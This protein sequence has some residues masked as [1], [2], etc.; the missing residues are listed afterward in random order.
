[1]GP[2]RAS[3]HDGI[4]K[5]GF[6][7][8]PR[9]SSDLVRGALAHSARY[10]TPRCDAPA[11]QPC[12]TNKPMGASSGVWWQHHPLTTDSLMEQSLEVEAL[13]QTYFCAATRSDAEV[14]RQ[15]RGGTKRGEQGQPW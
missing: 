10:A 7:H 13:D 1:L 4:R 12:R 14:R 2:E 3:A 15:R 6:G 8:A 5:Q 9:Q 11:C